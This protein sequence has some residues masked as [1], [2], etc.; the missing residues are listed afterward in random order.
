MWLNAST[1]P[2]VLLLLAMLYAGNVPLMK[3]LQAGGV[4]ISTILLVR[5]GLA[6][7]LAA[8]LLAAR[9]RGLQPQMLRRACE[10]ALY[11]AVGYRLQLAA[12]QRTPCAVCSVAAACTGVMVQ[13]LE[14]GV[15][16]KRISPVV[17]FSCLGTIAGVSLFSASRA[18]ADPCAAAASLVSPAVGS[19]SLDT[20][21]AAALPGEVLALLSTA[22]FAMRVWRSNKMLAASA[23]D[24]GEEGSALV[25]AAAQCT[26]V[27]VFCALFSLAGQ[28]GSPGR[29][30]EAVSSLSPSAWLRVSVCGLLCTGLPMLLEFFAFRHVPPTVVSLIYCSTPVWALGLAVAFLRE[31]CGL[32]TTIAGA[33]IVICSMTPSIAQLLRRRAEAKPFARIRLDPLSPS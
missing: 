10:L 16:G 25:M 8:P 26:L 17:A 33:I 1:A 6:T 18:S 28:S 31:A 5:F 29:L 2:L 27:F 23:E 4:P 21:L 30:L 15:D 9:V 11:V 20:W 14:C 19:A 3:S 13:L 22:C 32:Q 12:L 7:A 24:Q